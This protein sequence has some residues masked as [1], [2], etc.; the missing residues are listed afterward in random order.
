VTEMASRTI[1]NETVTPR[2]VRGPDQTAAPRNLRLLQ[3]LLERPAPAPAVEKAPLP[4]EGIEAAPASEAERGWISRL[5]T[6]HMA[7]GA[8][9]LALVAVP[10][11][12]TSLYMAFVA[13]D[14][15]HSSV[16]FSV[17]SIDSAQPAD[18]L[19]MFSQSSSGSTVSDSYVLLDYILSERMVQMVDEAFG[20]ETIFDRRGGD[21]FFGLAASQPIEDQLDYWRRMVSVSFDHTSG[22]MNLQTKAFEPETAQQVANFVVGQSE[23]L[24]NELSISARNETLR[25]AQAEVSSAEDRL[26]KT[27]AALRNYRDESQEA[28]PTEGAKLAAQLIGAL[29]T[30]LVQLRTEL[31]TALTQMSEDT[32]RVRVTRSQIAS[33]EKQLERERQRFGSGTVGKQGRNAGQMADVAG[34][35]QE[36]EGL[37]TQNEFAERAYTSSLAALEKAR[38][39]S[40]AKQRY[41]AVFI[42]PTLSEFAQYPHRIMSSLLVFLGSL[43]V[44]GVLVMG[45]YNIRDRN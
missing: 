40:A 17:R 36:Y 5:K 7:I 9:F 26:Y 45:Y 4:E 13:A 27:R 20:L 10:S 32:P 24:I 39:E 14:Q 28:D 38:I 31:S 30:Q 23:K 18:L 44:W 29:E 41:L 21:F 33:L 15:Y 6:R 1:A 3:A 35:I 25:V 22:I 42:K 2:I 37:Q 19:G 43:L 16:S 8:A 34:R 11:A 12:V